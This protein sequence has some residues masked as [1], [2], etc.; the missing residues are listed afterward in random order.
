MWKCEDCGRIFPSF[1][2]IHDGRQTGEDEFDDIIV[3]PYCGSE[4]IEPKAE[5]EA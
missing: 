4:E 1:R 3:C 2:V 5:E